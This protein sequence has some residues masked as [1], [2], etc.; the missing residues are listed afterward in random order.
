MRRKKLEFWS[1]VNGTELPGAQRCRGKLYSVTVLKQNTMRNMVKVH[2]DGYSSEDDEWK[3]AA[4]IVEVR[5]TVPAPVNPEPLLTPT[6]SLHREL[7]I[8]I[9]SSRIRMRKGSPED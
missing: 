2:Y 5:G 7:A 1:L 9:K 3:P 6:F 8:K 4:G